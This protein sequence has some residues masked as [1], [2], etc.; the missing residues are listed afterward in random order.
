MGAE[1][2][3]KMGKIGL[4]KWKGYWMGR[5]KVRVLE[6]ERGERAVS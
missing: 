1:M 4:K 6:V 3:R 2:G 5:E